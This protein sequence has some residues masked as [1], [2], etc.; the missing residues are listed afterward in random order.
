MN[1][2]KFAFVAAIMAAAWLIMFICAPISGVVA[3]A[4]GVA[5]DH[6]LGSGYWR[7][8]PI[9]GL[10]PLVAVW[11]VYCVAIWMFILFIS[12]EP[13]NG[14]YPPMDGYGK[15]MKLAFS[16]RSG[17]AVWIRSR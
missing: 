13:S 2:R 9:V 10:A 3:V 11:A 14:T 5:F 6:L 1:L 4:I 7:S 15:P 17:R 16:S 12:H 8:I